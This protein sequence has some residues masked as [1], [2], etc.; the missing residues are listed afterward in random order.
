[1]G[2]WTPGPG[3][4]AG[5]DTFEG[6]ATAETASGGD[7]NDTLN[8]AG[9]NDTLHGD[10]GKDTLNGGEG[11][12][13]LD[14][15]RNDDV[16]RGGAGNDTL[17]GGIGSGAFA[18]VSDDLYGDEGDDVLTAGGEVLNN[19]F[20]GEGNDVL[21]GGEGQDHL[22]GGADDDTLRGGE[23]RDELFGGDGDDT[24]NGGAD[25]D[26]ITGG[27]GADILVFNE[28]ELG[29]VDTVIGFETGAGMNDRLDLSFFNVGNLGM[30]LPHMQQTAEGATIVLWHDGAD[31]TIRL[32]GVSIGQLTPENFVFSGVDSNLN[33]L[34][35]AREDT[36]FGGFGDDLV[37]GR[38]GDDMMNGGAGADLFQY[39]QRGFGADT[40]YGFQA[41]DRI[42]VAS[43]GIGDLETLRPYMRETAGGVV[44]ELR[45]DGNAESIF[46]PDVSWFDLTEDSFMFNPD[47]FGLSMGGFDN[48]DILFGGNANDTVHAGGGNDELNGGAGNDRLRGEAGNDLIR[49]GLGDDRLEGG[50]GTNVLLG[51]AGTDLASY[52]TMETGVWVDLAAGAYSAAGTWDSF[53]SIEGLEGGE[54]NDALFGDDA[55]NRILGWRGADTLSG[56]DGN[57]ELDGEEGDDWLVGGQ[58]ADSLQ[59]GEGIDVVSSASDIAGVVV[60][61]LN[62]WAQ[63]GWGTIDTLAGIEGIVGSGF[64]DTLVGNAI[65]NGIIGDD[66]N[67]WIVGDA[68]DD[69]LEGGSG[70]N[71]LFGGD[72]VDLASYAAQTVGVWV[73][74]NAGV[75][76]ASGVWDAFDSIEG[77][78]GGTGDD[79]IFGNGGVNLLRGGAGN[80]ALIGN[81]GD[82][83]LE[84]GAGQDWLV[85]GVGSDRL[86]GGDGVDA[87]TGGAGADTFDLER[88]GGWDV[89]FDFNTGEDRFSLGGR[90]W[91]GFVTVDADGDG[92][93]DDTLLGYAG[94]NFVALNVSGLTLAQWN[95]LVDGAAGAEDSAV[96]MAATAGDV[97]AFAP[98]LI[99]DRGGAWAP[100][101]PGPRELAP[102]LPVRLSDDLQGWDLFG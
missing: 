77:V 89:G 76:S 79:S 9:G 33:I 93:S 28:H 36:L 88:S 16:L 64:N 51:G 30:L 85:G 39:L 13:T 18:P 48:A 53:D 94:G 95:A 96:A 43:I 101:D 38:G 19:L 83:R 60:H 91:T 67:D 78:L 58:G 21:N 1:M 2:V 34:G 41:N 23:N 68:G 71:A 40:I 59:G 75:Y 25:S 82:D 61:L 98:G 74:M 12:D 6:D 35:G 5:N 99:G 22:E 54:A 37:E 81:G 49:G 56:R 8:G 31:H 70:V 55:A 65:A 26:Q 80:D 86:V 44:I 52:R 84:G 92:Q 3:P 50:A 14:G 27:A 100:D 63:D 42:I 17:F 57:D 20:G 4:T 73:D 15:G 69:V 102:E 7:G 72:G 29:T 90:S 62:G 97:R 24:L 46:L 45:W 87:L 47:I 66:G 11:D 32:E 10:N